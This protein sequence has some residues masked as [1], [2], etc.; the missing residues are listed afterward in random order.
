MATYTLRGD[1]LHSF[2]GLP[3][4]FVV[5]SVTVDGVSASY[6]RNMHGLVLGSVPSRGA[7]VV[8]TGNLPDVVEGGG[9]VRSTLTLSNNRVSQNAAVGT[10]IGTLQ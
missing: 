1:G 7:V 10:T 5:T 2:A 6:T 3:A 8:I 9:G 4:K